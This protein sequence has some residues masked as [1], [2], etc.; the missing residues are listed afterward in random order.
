MLC[1]SQLSHNVVVCAT[2]RIAKLQRCSLASGW[3]TCT[4]LDSL[5][6]H[7]H[8]HTPIRVKEPQ[9]R[10]ASSQRQGAIHR[11]DSFSLDQLMDLDRES[12]LS[13]RS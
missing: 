2:K 5:H 8:T 4:I 1:P 9:V 12:L 3:Y 11:G 13:V 7:T 10:G 6:R